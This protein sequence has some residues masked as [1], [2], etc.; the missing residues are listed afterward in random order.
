MGEYCDLGIARPRG[1]L[2]A[3]HLKLDV[4]FQG[5]LTFN[6]YMYIKHQTSF[7][8]ENKSIATHVR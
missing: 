4:I 1:Y 2:S 8:L 7:V 5:N 3:T 6:L